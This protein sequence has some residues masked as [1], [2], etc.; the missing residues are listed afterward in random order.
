[1]EAGAD[2][3]VRRVEF[4]TTWVPRATVGAPPA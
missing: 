4:P 2:E 1:V 3:P